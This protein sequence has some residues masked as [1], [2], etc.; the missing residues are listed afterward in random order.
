MNRHPVPDA[1]ARAEASR[2]AGLV[3]AAGADPRR[4]ALLRAAAGSG[5]TKVLVDRLLRLLL[6]GAPLKSVVAVTFTRKA[7]VEIRG[8]LQ[9]RVAEL[10]LLDADALHAK[11]AE[12]LGEAPSETVLERAARL[13]EEL[14]EDPNGLLIGT[15]HTFAGAL[16]RRF[17]DVAGLDPAVDIL[18]R[19]DDL[20][21]EALDLLEREAAADP[22]LRDAWSAV[23]TRPDQARKELRA[24]CTDR[25]AL[26]RWRERAAPHA[27]DWTTAVPALEN[28]LTDALTAG[29]LLADDPSPAGLAARMADALRAYAAAG[30]DA[31]AAA[32]ADRSAKT[33]F[34]A[35]LAE[36][37]AL[38][39]QAAA[40]F[41]DGD[42]DAW[43]L[44]LASVLTLKAEPRSLGGNKTA[45]DD[46]QAALV[47]ATRP[48]LELWRAR[49]LLDL[50]QL[51][52]AHLRLG[53]RL[54]DRYAEL[55]RRDRVLDFHDLET[56]ARRL[57]TDQDVGPWILYRMDAR[58]DH[59][60]VDEFQDTNRDQW[61]L[62][63]PFAEEFLAARGEGDRARTVFFV[64][65]G[66]QSIY[67]F[68]G[69]RPEIFQETEAWLAARTGEAA[70]TLPTNFRSLASVVGCVGDAFEHPVLRD[71]LPDG[72][73]QLPY[74]DDGP[75]AVVLHPVDET[76]E[77]AEA[78]HDLGAARFLDLV[79]ELGARDGV[80]W[81]D[82]LVLVRS[83]SG[84][85]A[86]ERALRTAA[87]PFTPAGRGALADTR[88][89]RDVTALLRWLTFPADDIALTA[90]LR[91]PLLRR[92]EAAVQDLL[93]TRRAGLWGALQAR[94][95]D[96]AWNAVVAS[97]KSWRG[98]VGLDS[99][100]DLLRRVYRD[101]DALERCGAALGEQARY[102][103]LR[104]LDLALEHDATPFPGLRGF[105]RALDRAQ[106]IREHEEGTLPDTDRGRVR[107]MTI[108]GA[109]GLE[110]RFVILL[111]AAGGFREELPRVVLGPPG[112]DGP[113]VQRL[114]KAHRD[115]PDG[116]APTPLTTAADAALAENT[117]QEANLLY[118]A[119]TRAKDELHVLAVRGPRARSDHMRAWLEPTL[120]EADRDP[121]ADHAAPPPDDGAADAIH[122]AYAPAPVGGSTPLRAVTRASD[123]APP[124][125]PDPDDD[126]P[127]AAGGGRDAAMA[128]GTRIHLW[129]QRA[130]EAGAMPPGTGAEHAEAAAVFA[131]P[132]HAAVFHP[133]P[134]VPA[135][136]EAPLIHRLDDARNTRLLGVADRLLIGPDTVTVIDYKTNRARAEDLPELAAHYTP[137]MRAYGDALAAA[138]PGR[139]VELVLL[140][141]H[142]PGGV[143]V[144][145]A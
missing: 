29:T 89:V 139:R 114:T 113:V 60:L 119:M 3:Q 59:L 12:L 138:F 23:S 46:T 92:G 9:K 68:R 44:L 129:L 105:V 116:C 73:R 4:S 124:P 45:K 94:A 82:I 123:D 85:E 33:Q 28:D 57:V 128:R 107:M 104:L 42:A 20:W 39:L 101:T 125:L 5:K 143:A 84:L 55:K 130:C 131:N 100:H 49:A 1:A 16:L 34:P 64:G 10:A 117:R 17:A 41:A 31:V 69:A 109:K 51:N 97:L 56:L 112:A 61:D 21:D 136:D 48:V 121:P 141:T 86:Y 134:G 14:L 47:H 40:A 144:T 35:K 87:I 142:P 71:L 11:L 108:H 8:R 78:A 102:N 50:L 83:R 52:R 98:R 145:V 30:L 7:A 15:I 76:D 67:G 80:R 137:Q 18:E 54:L 140:F 111:N 13:P 25:T 95:D 81:S 122:D 135:Y 43:D 36:R 66:K 74:R 93:A 77:S 79:R 132:A 110:A 53:A 65:D 75:G 32:D 62:L 38:A 88:E 6:D 27:P 63:R 115:L 106:E 120:Q 19:E 37:R 26:D 70:A 22:G 99:V 126:A 127:A 2:L 91:S 133:A 72:A 58:L 103:L 24:W 90:V 96:P 118:V